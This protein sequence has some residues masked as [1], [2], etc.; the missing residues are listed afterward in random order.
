M[1]ATL[2][3]VEHNRWNV[4]KLLL[5]YRPV[6]EEEQK[7]I[8]LNIALKGDYRRSMI[9]YDIRPYDALCAKYE[10]L[11]MQ[12]SQNEVLAPEYDV[13]LTQALPYIVNGSDVV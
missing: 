9:H 7:K 6:T 1:T 10:A 12:L 13:A 8:D 5:G 3:I 4:E 2:S 11:R